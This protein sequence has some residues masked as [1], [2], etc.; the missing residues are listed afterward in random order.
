MGLGNSSLGR[1][2]IPWEGPPPRASNEKMGCKKYTKV[3]NLVYK[4]HLII[5]A[6]K[7]KKIPMGA[8][9][10]VLTPN[11]DAAHC[12]LTQALV[13]QIV[14]GIGRLWLSKEAS[15]KWPISKL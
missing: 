2:L 8:R 6:T 15:P 3:P 12:I 13:W 11:D 7:S 5:V 1:T 14:A 10:P 4:G 9:V